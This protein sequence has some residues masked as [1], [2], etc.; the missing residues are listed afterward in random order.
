M[1]SCMAIFMGAIRTDA[2]RTAYTSGIRNF[3]E[4]AGLKTYS[5][6]AR[7]GSKKLKMLIASYIEH[8]KQKNLTYST[9]NLYL[10][11]I[12]LFL[13]MNEVSYPKKVI[14]KLLPPATKK[15]GHK[16]YTT[17]EIQRMLDASSTSRTRALIHFFASTGCRPSALL[18]PPL[19]VGDLED[20]PG[21]CKAI[22]LYKGSREEYW[23][24]L[25]PD[26]A[27][28][29]DGYIRSRKNVT[30][31]SPLFATGDAPI[32]G[33]SV[34]DIFVRIVKKARIP[35]TKTG[36]RYDK[37]L[38]YGFRKRFN[39]ILKTT[40][41]L[42]PHIAERLMSHASTSIALDTVYLASDRDMFFAEFRKAIPYLEIDRTRQHRL[43]IEDLKHSLARLRARTGQ[44]AVQELSRRISE[45]EIAVAVRR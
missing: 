7:L 45:L 16:P 30:P 4:Y 26:A 35:R 19:R 11:P 12:E 10:A 2:T 13:D 40:G 9:I 23:S 24:F 1:E 41:G 15:Q 3:K 38:I 22:M 29:L 5:Q 36:A 18:D 6:L 43:E 14:R 21:G 32:S 25:T 8:L 28:A 39:T 17:E 42:N 33:P 37:S 27:A 34:R 20:M 31:D 44:D